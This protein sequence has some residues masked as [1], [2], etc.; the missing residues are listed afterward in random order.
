MFTDA[1][2]RT[3]SYFSW[4]ISGIQ[5]KVYTVTSAWLQNISKQS[6]SLSSW[7]KKWSSGLS[8]Q[9]WQSFTGDWNF[10][11]HW[12]KEKFA[13]RLKLYQFQVTIGKTVTQSYCKTYFINDNDTKMLEIHEGGIRR[14]GP[15]SHWS[16]W[17]DEVS[18]GSYLAYKA[19]SSLELAK[20]YTKD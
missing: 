19:P 3:M 7:E 14:T 4:R 16:Q 5:C 10:I 8:A 2:T 12:N 9:I 11:S 17:K 15:N 13:H 6:K 1:S 18:S 20:F